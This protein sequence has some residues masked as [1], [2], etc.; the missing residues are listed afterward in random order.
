MFSIYILAAILVICLAFI[1]TSLV[2]TLKLEK[3]QVV[4]LTITSIFLL[5][6]F[7]G[8]GSTVIKEPNYLDN[9]GLITMLFVGW[10]FST[11]RFANLLSSDTNSVIRY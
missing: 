6:I 5:I 4:D 11:L 3:Y 2:P 9:I 7:G 8:L 10:Y 1:I